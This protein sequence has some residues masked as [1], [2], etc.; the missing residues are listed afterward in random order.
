MDCVEKY[1]VFSPHLIEITLRASFITLECPAE[2]LLL[3][4][5][6]LDLESPP[7]K[8]YNIYKHNTNNAP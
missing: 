1:S 2:H 7:T 5:Q 8:I 6:I 4:S 3:A